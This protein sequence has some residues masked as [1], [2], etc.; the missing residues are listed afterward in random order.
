MNELDRTD[1][2]LLLALDE[3]CRLSFQALAD[4]REALIAFRDA[5]FALTVIAFIAVV[6]RLQH[7]LPDD[8][9]LNLYR[10]GAS[11]LLARYCT[12]RSSCRGILRSAEADQAGA[13]EELIRRQR[14]EAR[15]QRKGSYSLV[16]CV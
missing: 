15:G 2:L 4:N 3:N 7:H 14:S 13:G 10:F 8:A 11:E 5:N 12:E 9:S 6:E 16:F 1:K